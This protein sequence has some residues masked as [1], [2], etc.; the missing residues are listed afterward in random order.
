MFLREQPFR[1]AMPVPPHSEIEVASADALLAMKLTASRPGRDADDIRQLLA[2]CGVDSAEAADAVFSEYFPGDALTERAW[3]M[4]ER[5]LAD[6][7]L[8]PPATPPP[9]RL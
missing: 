4:V 6:G 2:I 3:S 9:G 8:D 5:I 7:P 1:L